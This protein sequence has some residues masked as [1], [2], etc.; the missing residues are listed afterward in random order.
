MKS[1]AEWNKEIQDRMNG[2]F[3]S[4]GSGRSDCRRVA[5]GRDEILRLVIRR[6]QAD[7]L[8][9]VVDVMGEGAYPVEVEHAILTKAKE[10][11]SQKWGQHPTQIE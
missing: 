4:V 2:F 11:E 5:Q 3:D 7:T 8:K 1:D 10:L 6:V 9:W